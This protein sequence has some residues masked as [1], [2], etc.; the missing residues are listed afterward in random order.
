VSTRPE[1]ASADAIIHL[2]ASGRTAIE[3]EKPD[4]D[5]WVEY[6][7][8]LADQTLFPSANSWYLGANVPGKPR[9]LMPFIGGFGVYRRIC[10][11][12][13]ADGYRGFLLA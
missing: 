11:E 2:D 9:V 1:S 7:N 12:V 3:P 6:C 4:Q 10:A 5:R 8:E 13:I